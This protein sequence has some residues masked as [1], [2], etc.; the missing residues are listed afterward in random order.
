M[1]DRPTFPAGGALRAAARAL[2]AAL[3]LTAVAGC[4]NGRNAA[5]PPP[6]DIAAK[7]DF[8]PG[9]A[10]VIDVRV[11][12]RD[13]LQQAELIAPDGTSYPARHIGH[14]RPQAGASGLAPSVVIAGG[15]GP[16]SGIDTGIGLS[17][18]MFGWG[19]P[20]EPQQESRASFDVP[21]MSLYRATWTL[22]RIHLRVGQPGDGG[23][24]VSFAAPPPP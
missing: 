19:G 7:A 12:D 17:L 3:T 23:R 16:R 2:L 18:P 20:S 11:H 1:N 10:G 15:G 21:D 8:R 9:A 13:P 5:A 22:W 6:S 14:D 24:N 4:S